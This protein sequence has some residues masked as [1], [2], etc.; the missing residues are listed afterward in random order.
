MV[1]FR[2]GRDEEKIGRGS[3]CP[4]LGLRSQHLIFGGKFR[5]PFTLPA[6]WFLIC[7]CLFAGLYVVYPG[8]GQRVSKL[9][10]LRTCKRITVDSDVLY[11]DAAK[12]RGYTFVPQFCTTVQSLQNLHGVYHLHSV[13]RLERGPFIFVRP[14]YGS[15]KCLS[16]HQGRILARCMYALL[17]ILQQLMKSWVHQV[18]HGRFGYWVLLS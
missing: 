6:P 16:K 18:W 17:V 8:T 15:E 2:V 9:Q 5:M 10:R 11:L 12:W 3:R 1:E 14:W 4:C 13:S 7:R